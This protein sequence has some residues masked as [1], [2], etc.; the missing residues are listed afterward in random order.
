M[1][2]R[3]EYMRRFLLLAVSLLLCCSP[4]SAQYFEKLVERYGEEKK[5]DVIKISSGMVKMARLFVTGKEKGL[6][7][8]IDNMSILSLKDCASEV[9][10][11]FLDEVQN[12]DPQGYESALHTDEKGNTSRVFVKESGENDI[13]YEMV[14][15]SVENKGDVV[16]M[17]MNGRFVLSEVVGIFK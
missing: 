10:E 12:V 3:T 16:L 6:F 9:K 15:S 5:A 4:V 1:D 2:S 13:A 11:R 8:M 7:R 14:V 17:I